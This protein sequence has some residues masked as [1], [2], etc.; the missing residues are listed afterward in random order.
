MFACYDTGITPQKVS[1]L[2]ATVALDSAT[3]G[4]AIA[5]GEV[6]GPAGPLFDGSRLEALYAS[7]PAYFP[8][9]FAVCEQSEPPTHFLWMI[10]ITRTEAAFVKSHGWSRFEDLLVKFDPDLLDLNRGEI[11]LPPS[12]ISILP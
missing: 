4:R 5:R 1:G 12:N 10:P 8:D 7:L 9:A 3:T 2:L 11:E 6:E